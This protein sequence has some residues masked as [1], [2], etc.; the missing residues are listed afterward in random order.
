MS[1]F[2]SL[3]LLAIS[4]QHHAIDA[5]ASIEQHIARTMEGAVDNRRRPR[6]S[7]ATRAEPQSRRITQPARKLTSASNGTSAC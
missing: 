5:A 1:H 6:I 2:A 3:F 7:A 4:V